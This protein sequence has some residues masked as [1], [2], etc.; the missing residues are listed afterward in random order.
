VWR[1]V[2]LGFHDTR[3]KFR[4]SEVGVWGVIYKSAVVF[5]NKESRLTKL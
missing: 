4:R 1:R 3:S 2:G 5:L